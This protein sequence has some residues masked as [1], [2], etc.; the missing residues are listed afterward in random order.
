M[1]YCWRNMDLKELEK[2]LEPVFAAHDIAKHAMRFVAGKPPVLEICIMHADGSMDMDCCGEV[3]RDIS[4]VLDEID[5]G[6]GA[7][8]LDVCSFGAEREL[9]REEIP[10]AVG[11]HVFVQLKNPAAGLDAVE[12]DLVM[13]SEESIAIEYSVKGRKKTAQ[14]ALDNIRMIR[15]AVRL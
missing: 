10:G 4:E 3:S 9:D 14:F 15:L 6:E 7:Y 2:R 1:N 11:E 8:N 13:C 5:Y 12:G